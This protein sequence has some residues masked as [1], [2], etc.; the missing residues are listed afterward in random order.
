M[1]VTI[2]RE[3]DDLRS[4]SCVRAERKAASPISQQAAQ[5]RRRTAYARCAACTWYDLRPQRGAGEKRQKMRAMR[6]R[7]CAR[8]MACA[9]CESRVRKSARKA[10]ARCLC[11]M[12][13]APA[14]VLSSDR[15]LRAATCY[16]DA[17]LCCLRDFAQ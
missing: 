12:A 5:C 4:R 15:H 7:A 2:S 14:R 9:V 8:R 17:H 16:G 3:R 13:E 1:R 10:R 11:A 6:V